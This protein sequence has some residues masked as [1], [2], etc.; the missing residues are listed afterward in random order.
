VDIFGLEGLNGLGFDLKPL[1][2]GRANC[3]IVAV[4]IRLAFVLSRHVLL[5][6]MAGRDAAST[7]IL[8]GWLIRPQA[9]GVVA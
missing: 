7:K 6:L 1:V 4:A 9:F 2:N 3:E 5:M 8:V